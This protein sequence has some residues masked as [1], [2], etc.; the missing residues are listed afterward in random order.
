MYDQIQIFLKS[1]VHSLNS[2]YWIFSMELPS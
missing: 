1:L 2:S